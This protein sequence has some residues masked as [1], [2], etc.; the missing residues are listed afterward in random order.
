MGNKMERM[1]VPPSAP[2]HLRYLTL[3]LRIVL[4]VLLRLAGVAALLV[5]LLAVFVALLVLLAGVFLATWLLLTAAGLTTRLTAALRL[6]RVGLLL[7]T[8]ALILTALLILFLATHKL[9]LLREYRSFCITPPAIAEA[10]HTIN[11]SIPRIVPGRLIAQLGEYPDSQC[12]FLGRRYLYEKL[13]GGGEIHANKC[14]S[15]KKTRCIIFVLQ[16][17]TTGAIRLRP[18]DRAL[19]LGTSPELNKPPWH[20]VRRELYLFEGMRHGHR[21]R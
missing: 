13:S 2:F 5:A 1:E 12:A 21:D 18:T 17:L 3:T 19:S 20:A 4:P 11:S 15:W 6:I 8:L 14:F 7:L 10:L 9:R 16:F